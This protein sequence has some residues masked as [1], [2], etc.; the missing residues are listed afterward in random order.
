MKHK[1]GDEIPPM[2]LKQHRKEQD[3]WRNK[4]KK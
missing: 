2:P 1:E 4:G 3:Q